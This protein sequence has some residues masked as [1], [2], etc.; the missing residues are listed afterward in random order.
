MTTA[1]QDYAAYVARLKDRNVQLLSYCCPHCQGAIETVQPPKGE[2]WDTLAS[3]PHCDEVFML[4]ADHD[5][6]Q[7]RTLE[8][9]DNPPAPHSKE[10]P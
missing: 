9:T 10:N 2:R 1:L 3:C 5:Q 8:D 6:A 7:G 4:L